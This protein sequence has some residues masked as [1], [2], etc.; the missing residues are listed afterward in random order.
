M[1][2]ERMAYMR[3]NVTGSTVQLSACVQIRRRRHGR[4]SKL[5]DTERSTMTPATWLT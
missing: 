5:M 2:I 4:M 1:S 3:D